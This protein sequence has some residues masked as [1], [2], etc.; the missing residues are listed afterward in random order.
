MEW[1]FIRLVLNLI[2]VAIS[3]LVFIDSWR[4]PAFFLGMYFV[5]GVLI[6]VALIYEFVAK[7]DYIYE[8]YLT[9]NLIWIVLAVS[10]IYLSIQ[11]Q[12]N[13]KS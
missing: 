3:I 12:K 4:L 10:F 8:L 6:R 2:G 11:H 1:L 7:T 5:S 13:N 9:A